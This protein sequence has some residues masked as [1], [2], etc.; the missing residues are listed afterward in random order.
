MSCCYQNQVQKFL[1]WGS[2]SL[3]GHRAVL[4]PPLCVFDD[5]C[6]ATHRANT[7]E[8]HVTKF[9]MDLVVV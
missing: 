1:T 6:I 2:L 4:N 8:P 7:R 9:H 5:R 3:F